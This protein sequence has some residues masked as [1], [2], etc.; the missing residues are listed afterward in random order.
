MELIDRQAAIEAITNCEPG[1]EVFM[2]EN[3]PSAQPEQKTGKWIYLDS[4]SEIYDDIKCPFCMRTF[5]VDAE[6]KCD[7]GFV[8]SDLKYCPHCG[9]KMEE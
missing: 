5:T 3:M 2:L 8:A 7:I 1:E 9:E 4:E 6:R